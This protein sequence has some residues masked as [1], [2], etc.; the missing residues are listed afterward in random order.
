MVARQADQAG[1]GG[2]EAIEVGIEVGPVE[3]R[4]GVLR[5]EVRV[6]AIALVWSR[7]GQRGSVT[8]RVVKR[9]REGVCG[10]TEVD[11]VTGEGVW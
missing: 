6:I 3:R 1:D 5:L 10:V 4:V 2:L 9:I 8:M 7:G 11:V